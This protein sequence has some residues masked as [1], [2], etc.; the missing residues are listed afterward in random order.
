MSNLTGSTGNA[1]ANIKVGI[2]SSDIDVYLA[3]YNEAMNGKDPTDLKHELTDVQKR[4][5]DFIKNDV[6]EIEGADRLITSNLRRIPG[7]REAQR[8]ARQL[9]NAVGGNVFSLFMVSILLVQLA[10]MIKQM[11]EDQMRERDQFERTIAESRG[12]TSRSQVSAWEAQQKMGVEAS[13]TV[14]R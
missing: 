5:D 2:D 12:Y 10:D 13:R 11:K 8:I 7:I 6:P 3:K 14:S 1:D 9:P 4:A